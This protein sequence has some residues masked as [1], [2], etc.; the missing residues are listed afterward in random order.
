MFGEPEQGHRVVVPWGVDGVMGVV[1]R[2][3]GPPGQRRALVAVP[4]Q[5]SSG[6]TLDETTVSVSLR[7]LDRAR[8]L[9]V[10]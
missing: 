8:L 7:A 3:Y 1:K 9:P 6:E 2:V 4:I 5:S 10:S